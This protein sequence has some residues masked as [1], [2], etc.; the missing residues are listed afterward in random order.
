MWRCRRVRGRSVV[1]FLFIAVLVTCAVLG[2]VLAAPSGTV[3]AAQASPAATLGCTVMSAAEA[4]LHGTVEPLGH[5][6]VAVAAGDHHSLGVKSD[7]TLWAWGQNDHGQLGL[8]DKADRNVPTKVSGSGWVAVS[9][10]YSYSLGL[11]SDGSLWGWGSNNHGQ[12]G[13][14]HAS[15]EDMPSKLLGNDW[16]AVDAGL[17]HSLGLKSNGLLYAWGANDCG[18]LGLGDTDDRWYPE[19]VN[20]AD[21]VAVS[22]GE[23]YSLGLQD[24]GTLWGWGYNY[25]Y[26]LGTGDE[27][28]YGTDRHIPTRVGTDTDWAEVSAG[29]INSLGVKSDGTLWTWGCDIYGLWAVG[30]AYYWPSPLQI[31]DAANWVAVSAGTPAVHMTGYGL[32]LDDEGFLWSWWDNRFGELGLGDDSPRFVGS[33]TRIDVPT[34]WATVSAGGTHSLGVLSDGSLWAWGDNEYGQLGLGDYTSRYAPTKVWPKGRVSFEWGPTTAYGFTTEPQEMT[35]PGTFS[36]GISLTSGSPPGT[37]VPPDIPADAIC[38]YRARV[39]IDDMTYYGQDRAFSFVPVS[40]TIDLDPN[41]LNLRSRGKSV[42]C[43]IELPSGFDVRQ[44]DISTVFLNG[45]VPPLA[46]PAATRDHDRDGIPDLMVKFDR[47][48][49]QDILGAGGLV[50]VTVSGMAGDSF[51]QGSDT[52]RVV[53]RHTHHGGGCSHGG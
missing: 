4:M 41:T 12:L 53:G 17:A 21:W 27:G 39:V 52:I 48:R 38:H 43:Y 3:Q 23:A 33:L 31:E 30:E 2:G 15:D 25:L 26:Q 35:I 42:T 10:G 29:K 18:Q 20:Y 19:V 11:K 47:A 46:K 22:A 50:E 1:R 9:A 44:I 6:F 32:A 49:V 37:T 34:D 14:G 24:D 13:L 28:G 5:A 51:F 16:V 45:V 7:G 8:G 40:A 36:A